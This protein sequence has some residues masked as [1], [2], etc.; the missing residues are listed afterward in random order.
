MGELATAIARH[1]DGGL[2]WLICEGNCGDIKLDGFD[3]LL[4]TQF[5]GADVERNR[6]LGFL[7]DNR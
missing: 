6:A 5:E 1:C 2:I 4:I 7:I 3:V